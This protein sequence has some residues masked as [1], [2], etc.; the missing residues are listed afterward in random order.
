M[1]VYKAT[2]KLI[3]I[4]TILL[5]GAI[6]INSAVA[7]FSGD[8]DAILGIWETEHDHNGWAHVEIFR[9]GDRYHGKIIWLS[10]PLCPA[11]DPDGRAGLHR[12]DSNNRDESL[13][14]RP[15]VGLEIVHSFRYDKELKWKDGRIY[16]PDNGKTYKC[17]VELADEDTLKVRGF[18]G[19]SMLGRTTHWVR[20]PLDTTQGKV[21]EP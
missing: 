12:I 6:T 8:P 7:Q 21:P 20:V 9:D 1:I 15:I 11:D 14:T 5:F 4:F 2:E 16:D 10:Q 18:I 19:F 17:K 3:Y 13:R